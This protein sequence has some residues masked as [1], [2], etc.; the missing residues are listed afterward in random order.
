MI[1]VRVRIWKNEPYALFG[2]TS[3][4]NNEMLQD[5]VLIKLFG[6]GMS[7]ILSMKSKLTYPFNQLL[8][9]NG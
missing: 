5:G 3:L 1:R 9:M 2:I 7:K 8:T 4:R 6:V